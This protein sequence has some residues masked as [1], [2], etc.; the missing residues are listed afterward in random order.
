MRLDLKGDREA[1]ANVD[2]A[3]ILFA[4][5]NEDLGRFCRK[6]FE[7]RPAVFIRAMLA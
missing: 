1:I 7:Q 6:G 5:A 3:G 4:G 2:D